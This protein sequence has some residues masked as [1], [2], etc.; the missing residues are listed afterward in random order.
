MNAITS[1]GFTGAY[2]DPVSLSYPL[3]NGYRRHM[4]TVHR[5]NAQD[6]DSPFGFGGINPYAYCS[7]DPINYTDPTGHFMN[8]ATSNVVVLAF[9][10]SVLGMGGAALLGKTIYA[11]LVSG[12]RGSLFRRHQSADGG[13]DAPHETAE[14]PSAVPGSEVHDTSIEPVARPPSTPRDH[15]VRKAA[16]HFADD[17]EFHFAR[18][19]Q[20]FERTEI[21]IADRRMLRA[22]YDELESGGLHDLSPKTREMKMRAIARADARSLHGGR[23]NLDIAHTYL[24]TAENA[25]RRGRAPEEL[26]AAVLAHS[27]EYLRLS[28]FLEHP[29]FLE[30]RL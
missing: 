28:N 2:R 23:S 26:H 16:V 30:F 5:F 24:E 3:G 11:R 19:Q 21:D 25:I 18:A 14:R 29:E 6:E 4:G 12:D 17:L 10:G 9:A 20:Y 7:G 8:I 1:L 22:A 13:V 27:T 15:P